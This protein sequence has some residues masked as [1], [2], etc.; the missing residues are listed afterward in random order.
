MSAQA[1]ETHSLSCVLRHFMKVLN[2]LGKPQRQLEHF[3]SC[4]SCYTFMVTM[5]HMK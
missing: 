3:A 1:D 4:E 5:V 2:N